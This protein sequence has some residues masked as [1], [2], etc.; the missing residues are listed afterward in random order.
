MIGVASVILVGSAI[1]GLGVYA[2]QST[3][4]AFGSESFVH[5]QVTGA[6]SRKEF[7]D[8]QR[9]NRQL[10]NDDQRYLAAVNGDNVLYSAFRQS[11]Q[12]LKRDNL[13][14]EDVAITGASAD[15]AEIRDMV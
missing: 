13:T 8:K 1:D 12:D 4:K 2:E 7:F 5:Q 11:V 14:C 3:S 6:R 15:I 10:K 9:Y